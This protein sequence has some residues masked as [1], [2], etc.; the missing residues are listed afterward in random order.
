[1]KEYKVNSLRVLLELLE[2]FPTE[3]W[4]LFRGQEDNS[5]SVDS[6]FVRSVLH[7]LSE[8]KA[9]ELSDIMRTSIDF[10]QYV[11]KLIHHKRAT[12]NISEGMNK[13]GQEN[14]EIDLEFEVLKFLQQYPKKESPHQKLLGTHI[15]D[16]TYDPFVALYFAVNNTQNIP[17][18]KDAAVYIYHSVNTLNIVQVKKLE[19]FY[20]LMD[21]KDYQNCILGALPIIFHPKELIKDKRASNQKSIYI[22][23]MDFRYDLIEAWKRYEKE[24]GTEIISK[25]VISSYLKNECRQYLQSKGYNDSFIYPKR[26]KTL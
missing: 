15:V 6:K 26:I 19:E 25:I 20:S 18:H 2:S 9:L 8:I 23:Q 7:D 1:M 16:W 14:P 17:P 4:V 3:S 24:T 11:I 5:W 22:A 13:F 10:H 21:S 12:Y